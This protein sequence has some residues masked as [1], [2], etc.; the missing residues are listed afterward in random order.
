MLVSQGCYRNST[1]SPTLGIL[2]QQKY[3]LS[4][5]KEQEFEMD[6]LESVP[7]G[8]P[9]AMPLPASGSLVVSAAVLDVT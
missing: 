2:K 6:T 9:C 5:Y 8:T 3:I 1:P 4:Q 7:C